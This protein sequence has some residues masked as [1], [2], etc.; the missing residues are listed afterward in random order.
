[1]NFKLM[2][3]K[4][5]SSYKEIPWAKKKREEAYPTSSSCSYW[6]QMTRTCWMVSAIVGLH[7][8]LIDMLSTAL[9]FLVVTSSGFPFT[10]H[11]I[12]NKITLKVH[13]KYK[14]INQSIVIESL[15]CP[16]TTF[17][18]WVGIIKSLTEH[19]NTQTGNHCGVLNM[20]YSVFIYIYITG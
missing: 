20:T 2:K 10:L 6:N 19:P 7:V 16:W 12:I 4:W 17:Q 14:A 3:K 15:L 9:F 18:K 1:M 8:V 11:I 13:L 5:Y